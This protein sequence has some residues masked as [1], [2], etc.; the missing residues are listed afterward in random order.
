MHS[1]FFSTIKY[2]VY[3]DL[4]IVQYFIAGRIG[5]TAGIQITNIDLERNVMKIAESIVWDQKNKTFFVLKP[6]PK[7]F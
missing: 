5:E 6:L 7:N 3:R 4:A 1:N 2:E